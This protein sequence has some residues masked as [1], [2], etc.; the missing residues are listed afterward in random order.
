MWTDVKDRED[1]ADTPAVRA[2]DT[3]ER[4]GPS[5]PENRGWEFRFFLGIRI[6]W[7]ARLHILSNSFF[8]KFASL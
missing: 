8:L 6:I 2:D 3:A 4:H 1:H 5:G 7:L